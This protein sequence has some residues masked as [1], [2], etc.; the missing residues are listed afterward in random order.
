M[1]KGCLNLVFGRNLEEK[2]SPVLYQRLQEICQVPSTFLP[3]GFK[4]VG[5][6]QFPGLKIL[7]EVPDKVQ[8][9]S[10]RIHLSKQKEEL[11]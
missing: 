4:K 8:K 11:G 6:L 3:P 5:G 2:G 1:K 10:M 7:L 9:L